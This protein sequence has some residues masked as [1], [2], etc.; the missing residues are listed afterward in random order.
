MII[1]TIN[2]YRICTLKKP[3]RFRPVRLFHVLLSGLRRTKKRLF[4]IVIKNTNERAVS[5]VICYKNLK[6]S[7]NGTKFN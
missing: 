7:L 5:L 6:K 1:T 3:D 2:K 4:I